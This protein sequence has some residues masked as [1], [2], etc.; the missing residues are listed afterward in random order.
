MT[1]ETQLKQTLR[2]ISLS[3]EQKKRIKHMTDE[4]I[5][6]HYYIR[7]ST[8]ARIVDAAARVNIKPSLFLDLIFADEQT[9]S[10]A[11]NR[12]LANMQAVL[13]ET[14]P[15]PVSAKKK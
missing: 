3:A 2:P 14:A 15:K 12:H 6:V 8:E 13:Q 7:Q 4:K 10:D 9:I 1:L 5:S 11:L